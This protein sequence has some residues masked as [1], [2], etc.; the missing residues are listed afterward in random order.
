VA[1][2][3]LKKTEFDVKARDAGERLDAERLPA[4]MDTEEMQQAMSTLKAFSEKTR[5]YRLSPVSGAAEL[6]AATAASS[7]PPACVT[8]PGRAK[9]CSGISEG[10]G[11]GIEAL[12]VN[13]RS[14]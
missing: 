11:V 10:T 9:P 12:Q 4:W 5:A 13:Q 3:K 6:L 14:Q 1:S 2:A 8:H 7:E